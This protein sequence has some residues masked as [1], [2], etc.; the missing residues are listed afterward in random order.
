[1]KRKQVLFL[2]IIIS[3]NLL[4]FPAINHGA[5]LG[6]VTASSSLAD[7]GLDT[8]I[9]LKFEFV[10]FDQSLTNESAIKE[11]LYHY[12]F[13]GN[14]TIGESIF[15]ISLVFNYATQSEYDD[16][17]DYIE[18]NAEIGTGVGYDINRTQLENDIAT[19]QRNDILIPH[20]GLLMEA[21]LT[22]TYI[23]NNLYSE[24]ILNPGYTMYFLN[25]STF[26]SEDHSLEHWYKYEAMDFDTNESVASWFSGYNS[27]PYVPTLGWGG[28][29][30]FC[31]LDLSARTW[32]YDWVEIAWGGYFGGLGDY[33]YYNYKDLDELTQIC[34]IYTEQ[35]NANYTSYLADYIQSYISNI[36]CGYY[37]Q[38]PIVE[39]YSLQVKVFNNLTNIG[40]SSDDVKWVISKTRIKNQ[41]EADFPWIEWKIDVEFVN[42]QDYPVI[43]NYIAENV[44]YDVNGPYVEIMNGLFYLLADQLHSHFD[45]DAAETILPCYF[46]ITDGL[47]FQY[48]GVPFAGLGGMGWEILVS[49]QYSMFSNGDANFP[50]A[51]MSATTIH[52][53]GHSLGF[54]HPHSA[55]TGWGSSFIEDVMNYFSRGEESFSSFYI[56]ALAR[57]HANY[58]Y[59][60]TSLQ[61]DFAY[62]D[63]EDAGSPDY[64][65]SYLNDIGVLLLQAAEQYS[66]MNYILS[67]ASSKAAITA[68][69]TFYFALD[70]PET[71]TTPTLEESSVYVI[72]TLMAIT[73]L[74]SFNI[75]NRKRK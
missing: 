36:F 75:I 43:Y 26:D 27:F 52:E 6:R 22:E 71:T 74:S 33:S 25:F 55:E 15:N 60:Y 48:G 53:L 47:G 66:N 73:V 72:F 1:M 24:D 50:R 37:Y 18:T 14:P 21:E 11:K 32:Y 16:F 7:F 40:Y 39:S 70:N 58:F 51:G 10:G 19:G 17:I 57:S 30:R 65:V 68:I 67:I 42:I 28:N 12:F 41:L 31:Y 62:S 35:G 69:D 45:Y 38:T 61:Q 59:S 13:F 2:T 29:H 54:P 56:D 23:F 8:D 46:F 20:D 49:T 9:T 44:Q 34:D 3:L 63:F 64:L 5:Y 4:L